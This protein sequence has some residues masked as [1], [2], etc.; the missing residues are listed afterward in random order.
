MSPDALRPTDWPQ[1]SALFD[2]VMA[3]PAAERLPFLQDVT[4]D[5]AVRQEVRSL[6]AHTDDSTAG[7]LDRPAAAVLD[8]LGSTEPAGPARESETLDG[9]TLGAWTI[10]GRLGTGGMGEVWRARRS[11]G[12]YEGQ[13]AIKVLKRGMDSA[14]LL[15]RFGQEQRALARLNHPHIGRLYDAGLTPDG[16][17]Y[18]VMEL[19]DGQPIDRAV[20]G[21][22]LEQRLALFLQLADAVA[23]A[24]R[25]LLVHRDL[26][27]GNVLVDAQG[28][29]KLLDFGIAKALDPLEAE[30][31]AEA[32]LGGQRPFTPHYASPEQVRGEPVSTATD[33]YSLGVLLYVMLTGQRP[34]GRGTSHPTEA[35]R[36][37]LDEAPTRPS[38]LGDPPQPDTQWLPTRKRLQ[39]DLD[40]L[41]LKAL[42]KPVDRRYAS[43]DA[44]AADV[45][46]FLAGFPVS[47]RPASP[48]YL[49][50][51]FLRRHPWGAAAGSL[52]TLAVL[53]STGVAFWQAREATH[54]MNL[55]Q[56]RMANVGSITRDV[57]LRYGDAM[58]TLPGGLP[59]KEQML[60]GLLANLD[61]LAAEAGDDPVW[62]ADLA[63]AYARL[64][65]VQGNDT[66]L[67]VNKQAEAVKNADR[68][69][70]LA[71]RAWPQRRGDARF[72]DAYAEALQVRAQTQRA[73]GQP[74][75]GIGL[76]ERAVN[77]LDQA[78]PLQQ[79]AER[80]ALRLRRG[81][82]LITH[83]QFH[84]QQSIPSLD[85]PEKALALYARSEA[86][87]LA[88]DAEQ[89]DLETG[90][91][92][93]SLY[94]GRAITHG[95]LSNLARARADAEQALRYR[96]RAVA[97][98][99]GN[100]AWRDRLVN[101]A[102]NAGV[103]L[104]R[105]GEPG[106]ALQATQTAWDHVQA[107]A[108]E[109]GPGNQWLALQPRVAQHHARALLANQRAAE[110]LP[111]VA[112]A[113]AGWQARHAAQPT[114]HTERMTAWMALQQAKAQ[115]GAGQPTLA[116]AGGQRVVATLERLA[117]APKA[118]DAMLN[119]GEACL[120]MAAASPAQREPWRARARVAYERA[121]ELRP[122]TGDHLA[123]YR[124]AGG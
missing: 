2:E 25:Q 31:D 98:E 66:G 8:L 1:V 58:T 24:H 5:E 16:R 106:P 41:L 40:R 7:P 15:Q 118:G 65:E 110:A 6:L 73:A 49:A 85:L 83:A 42:E 18:F 89:A 84:D 37:V 48:W 20:Q 39:G 123:N 35:A 23:Y 81:A 122:L 97:A 96:Q 61:R 92:L 104:L 74:A 14:A 116:R 4:A 22:A 28:Q 67:S 93:A 115:W 27:P 56:A 45:R 87:L 99:P 50:A 63:A 70:A 11:D 100:V 76:L 94:A 32:T 30:A 119:L 111:V 68:A 57:V 44:L 36:C 91:L 114:P 19:V 109:N 46:A 9:Q 51:K 86:E 55:A 29:V 71:E 54:A 124:A 60:Q 3:L 38:A 64:A 72:V 26:K 34:Y 62:L 52:A 17:P 121:A 75:Q 108:R 80:R 53:A 12:A 69:I 105:A 13:A 107:L 10:N 101:D 112:Q 120:F 21:L 43:V 79:G 102:T 90:N 77:L 33:V 88:L 103:I 113:L 117:A 59:L 95:R 47:A 78:L 82:V